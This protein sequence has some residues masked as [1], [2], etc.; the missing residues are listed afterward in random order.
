MALWQN[1]FAEVFPFQ[2]YSAASQQPP[3]ENPGD[4]RRID[5]VVRPLSRP[6]DHQAEQ[7]F[8]QTTKSGAS[9]FL[10]KKCEEQAL[11]TC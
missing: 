5:L 7:L 10:V 11:A 9:P 6:D 2:Q 1:I 8:V 3:T 4:R